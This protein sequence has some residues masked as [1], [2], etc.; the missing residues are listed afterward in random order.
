MKPERVEKIAKLAKKL[1]KTSK[2]LELE[3]ELHEIE[4]LGYKKSL[5]YSKFWKATNGEFTFS[6]IY[7][8]NYNGASVIFSDSSGSGLDDILEGEFHGKLL[9]HTMRSS[10][11]VV[12]DYL[13]KVITVERPDL[14]ETATINGCGLVDR[15][16]FKFDVRLDTF[17][18]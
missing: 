12:F 6:G 11:E 16:D 3:H 14:V 4:S 1:K 10:P 9:M 15:D 7:Q 17:S 2:L 8:K 13:W 18:T 5:Y